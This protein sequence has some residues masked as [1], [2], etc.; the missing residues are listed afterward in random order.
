LF[1]ANLGAMRATVYR[2]L[3]WRTGIKL[4]ATPRLAGHQCPSPPKFPLPD[5]IGPMPARHHRRSAQ[6]LA[7]QHLCEWPSAESRELG[8]AI[9]RVGNEESRHI[10]RDV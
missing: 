9:A 6:V 3:P 1:A 4:P 10:Q 7:K 8:Q 5:W 2:C